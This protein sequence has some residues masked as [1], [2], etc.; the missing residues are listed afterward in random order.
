MFPSIKTINEWNDFMPRIYG[1]LIIMV[2]RL[3]KF[4]LK[5]VDCFSIIQAD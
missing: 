5:T 3:Y 2:C 4:G 1:F